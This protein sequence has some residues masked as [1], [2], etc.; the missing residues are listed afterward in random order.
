MLTVFGDNDYGADAITGE[1]L[2]PGESVLN[3]GIVCEVTPYYY[4]NL[5]RILKESTIVWLAEQAGFTVT[6]G[7]EGDS[8]DATSV[9][10]TNAT[11]GAGTS[12][13]GRLAT[14]GSKA[15]K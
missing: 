7:D 2:C 5:H 3:T 14:R 12:K 1:R 6:R 13:V 11:N 15:A 4:D 8:R 9:E 10:S